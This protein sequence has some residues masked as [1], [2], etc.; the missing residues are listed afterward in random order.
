MSSHRLKIPSLRD[1]RALT[2]AAC[3]VALFLGSTAVRFWPNVGLSG[4]PTEPTA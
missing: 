2:I 1:G 3:A 4:T